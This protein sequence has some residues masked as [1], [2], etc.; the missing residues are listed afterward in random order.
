MIYSLFKL[1]KVG[2]VSM[3]KIFLVYIC[4]CVFL[5]LHA[6][7]QGPCESS[8]FGDLKLSASAVKVL[9][10]I[11]I[12]DVEGLRKL[13][14]EDL[15]ELSER[16]LWYIVEYGIWVILNKIGIHTE[17]DLLQLSGRA[18]KNLVR[19]KVAYRLGDK[20]IR[21]TKRYLSSRGQSLAHDFLMDDMG[22]RSSTANIINEH[23]IYG[24]E[25]FRKLTEREL[26][27][28]MERRRVVVEKIKDYL[29]SRGESLTR[30]FLVDD[31]GFSTQTANVF[32]DFGIRTEA[33]F[34]QL[35][36]NDVWVILQRKPTVADQNMEKVENYLASKGQSLARD[37]LVSDVGLSVEAARALNKSGI[38]TVEDLHVLSER[39]LRIILSLESSIV[40]R[41]VVKTVKAFLFDRKES[42]A[43][44]FLVADVG[45]SAKAANTLNRAGIRT[46]EDLLKWTENGLWGLYNI[47]KGSIEKIK[48]YLFFRGEFLAQD[49]VIEDIGLS[50][51][52]RPKFVEAFKK[53]KIHT[54]EDLRKVSRRELIFILPGKRTIRRA[55]AQKIEDYLFFR[56]ESLA[57]DFLMDDIGLF[58]RAADT[59]NRAGIRTSEDLLRWTEYGLLGLYFFDK[60]DIERVKAYF[61]ERGQSLKQGVL[62][63]G[64][65]PQ[66]APWFRIRY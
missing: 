63:E 9:N 19:D 45:L 36:K 44:D 18:L 51:G 62:I 4:F 47:D 17:A 58:A 10:K 22:F 27:R 5:P 3:L 35:T 23:G 48:D 49:L 41:R 52:L 16:Q 30:D 53:A 31:I 7:G 25:G 12:H 40:K 54:I 6:L 37:F 55:T 66:M 28:I 60:N 15:G 26:I 61:S 8:A 57:H 42:L 65:S 2:A 56:G 20:V 38:R 64:I 34:L 11:G 50:I 43:R 59:L 39:E 33:D 21:R 13:D 46:S 24:A 1:Y 14:I 29:S 32:S